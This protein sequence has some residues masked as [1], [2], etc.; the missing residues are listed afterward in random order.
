[1]SRSS[2][3]LSEA[4]NTSERTSSYSPVSSFFISSDWD[5]NNRPQSSSS[6]VFSSVPLPHTLSGTPV[7]AMDSRQQSSKLPPILRKKLLKASP[8]YAFV[9]NDLIVLTSQ[10]GGQR[11]FQGKSGKPPMEGMTLLDGLGISRILGV[12]DRSSDSGEI[13]R[14]DHLQT[15]NITDMEYLFQVD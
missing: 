1:M 15:L 7:Q 5:P 11:H 10:S 6:S 9:F 2:L 8:V 14:F 3:A 13:F 4:S 12:I